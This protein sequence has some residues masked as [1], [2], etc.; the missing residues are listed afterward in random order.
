MVNFDPKT[1]FSDPKSGYVPISRFFKGV[2]IKNGSFFGHFLTIFTI[3]VIL[4]HF[5]TSDFFVNLTTFF[6]TIAQ[7]G[8]F[9][10][11]IKMTHRNVKTHTCVFDPLDRGLIGKSMSNFCDRKKG[12]FDPYH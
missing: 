8:L 9:F 4:D 3:F 11:P 1:R 5:G 2:L 7:C 12:V 10:S 6:L